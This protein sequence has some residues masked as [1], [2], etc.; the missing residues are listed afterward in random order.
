MSGRVAAAGVALPHGAG[1]QVRV[2]QQRIDERGLADARGAE[3]HRGPASAQVLVGQ[4]GYALAGERR[5]HTDLD[6]G[7]DGTRGDALAIA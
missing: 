2:T 6:A 7:G 1:A 5:D 4:R 3:H